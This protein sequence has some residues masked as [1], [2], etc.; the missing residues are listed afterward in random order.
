MTSN[1]K[2]LNSIRDRMCLFLR[3]SAF[4]ESKK[5]LFRVPLR[6]SFVEIRR[7]LCFLIAY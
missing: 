3:E 6:V 5:G 2:K 7:E 1:V 4:K